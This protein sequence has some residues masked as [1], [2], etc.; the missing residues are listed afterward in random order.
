M[1]TSAPLPSRQPE[2][3]EPHTTAGL[4]ELARGLVR[5]DRRTF[6]GITGAPG[7]GKSTL[8][9]AVVAALGDDAVLVSMDGF[10]LRDD[11]P[12]RLGRLERKGAIDT[13]DVAG[14]AHLLQRLSD[15]TDAVVYV[16]VFDRGLEESSLRGR[17]PGARAP[18]RRRGQLPAGRGRR[19][20][21]GPYGAGRLLVRRPR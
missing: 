5:T 13:F 15:R 16:P 17:G 18:R 10:H 20:G 9:E 3:P 1:A 6:L 12:A 19:L 2:E 21:Q 14:F 7:P 11:E 8:A 4:V